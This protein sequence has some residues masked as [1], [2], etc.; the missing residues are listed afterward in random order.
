MSKNSDF[1]AVAD[2]V[3][4]PLLTVTTILSSAYTAIAYDWFKQVVSFQST[5]EGLT[6]ATM[7]ILIRIIFIVP[8]VI[9][10][11]AWA[12][13]EFRDSILWKSVAWSGLIYCLT[14]DFVGFMALFGFSLILGG[15][16]FEG[17]LMI[18]I[19]LVILF[20]PTMGAVLGYRIS[21]GYSLCLPEVKTRKRRYIL[22]ASFTVFFLLIIQA[23]LGLFGAHLMGIL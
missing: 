23:L 15:V 4:K 17:L 13:S 1:K 11:L 10:L 16:M 14:Q 5:P 9:Y 19:L 8:I 6:Q 7:G 20:P 18:V 12:F 2:S 3:F 22:T 21:I